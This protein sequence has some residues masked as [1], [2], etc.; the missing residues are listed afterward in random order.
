MNNSTKAKY[1]AAKRM[2][3]GKIDPEEVSLMMGLPLDEVLKLKEEVAPENRDAKVLKD[4]DNFDFNIGDIL[5][6]NY[7]EDEHADDNY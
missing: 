2:L 4:Q 3:L 1:D 7:V 5:V 6:D